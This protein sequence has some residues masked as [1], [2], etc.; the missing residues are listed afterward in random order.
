MAK[1]RIPNEKPSENQRTAITDVFVVV[2]ATETKEKRRSIKDTMS[3]TDLGKL[4][5]VSV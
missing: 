3:F 4:N 5:L 1:S 2:T